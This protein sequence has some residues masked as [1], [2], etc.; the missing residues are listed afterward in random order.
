MIG[1]PREALIANNKDGL[2]ER[3]N[4]L[5]QIDSYCPHPT[6]PSASEFSSAMLS[7]IHDPDTVLADVQRLHARNTYRTAVTPTHGVG[8]AK[9]SS[10]PATDTSAC[11]VLQPGW[12]RGLALQRRE[13]L[14]RFEG[15]D[16]GRPVREFIGESYLHG[17]MEGEALRAQDSTWTSALIK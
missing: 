12:R 9:L 11:A 6:L 7:V 4:I 8:T 15:E 16:V 13:A 17:F 1:H 5:C 14:L 3:I 2:S 10:S